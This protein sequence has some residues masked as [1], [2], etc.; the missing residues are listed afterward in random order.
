MNFKHYVA[1]EARSFILK[2]LRKAQKKAQ[3]ELKVG[4]KFDSL[5]RKILTLLIHLESTYLS[6]RRYNRARVSLC[7]SRKQPFQQTRVR[8]G[9][10]PL[11]PNFNQLHQSQQKKS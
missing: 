2:K 11:I 3:I 9:D 4:T 7:A 1:I 10:F 6:V 5:E 8:W